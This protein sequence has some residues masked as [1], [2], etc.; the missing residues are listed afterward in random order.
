MLYS[1]VPSGALC[2]VARQGFCRCAWVSILSAF[3]ASGSKAAVEWL[4]LLGLRWL[5]L[6]LPIL[7]PVQSYVL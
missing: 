3:A 4:L 5:L 7:G 2:R 6:L 1:V